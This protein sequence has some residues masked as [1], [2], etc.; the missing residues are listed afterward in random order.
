MY[1]WYALY[2]QNIGNKSLFLTFVK[3]K[4]KTQVI[5]SGRPLP[6]RNEIHH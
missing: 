2:L 4:K 6:L 1:V 3:K 5:I